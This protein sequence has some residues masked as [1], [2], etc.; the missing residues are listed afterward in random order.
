MSVYTLRQD[1]VYFEIVRTLSSFAHSLRSHTLFVRVMHIHIKIL[2][3]DDEYLREWYENHAHHHPGDSGFDLYCPTQLCIDPME[4]GKICFGIAIECFSSTE[5]SDPQ[6]VSCWLTPRSSISKTPLRM[7][8]SMGLIDSGYRGELMAY[9]DNFT[10]VEYYECNETDEESTYL[11]ATEQYNPYTIHP[12]QRLFQLV[13]PTLDPITFEIV[14][15]LSDTSR[16]E[17]GF[18]STGV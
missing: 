15:E 7:S 11:T 13:S 4:T 1:S 17:G 14:D 6:P 8:N 3:D 10:K 9:V 5:S 12:K 18:G 2:N 16:G